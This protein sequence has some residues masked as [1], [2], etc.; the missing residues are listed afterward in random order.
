VPMPTAK[1]KQPPIQKAATPTQQNAN[2]HL[3]PQVKV[4]YPPTTAATPNTKVANVA[5]QVNDVEDNDVANTSTSA[6]PNQS[7][8]MPIFPTKN[9]LLARNKGI[10]AFKRV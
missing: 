2:P 6:Q 1:P 5:K 9:A 8:R 10:S 4:L 3:N 7:Q